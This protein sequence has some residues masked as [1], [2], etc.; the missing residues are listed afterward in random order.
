MHQLKI[1]ILLVFFAVGL[2]AAPD[3]RRT[4]LI[5]VT[6]VVLGAEV[7]YEYR[8]ANWAALH[9]PVMLGYVHGNWL[10]GIAKKIDPIF[11]G[12]SGLDDIDVA[13][14]DVMAGLGVK[15]Y[16]DGFDSS[17]SWYLRVYGAGGYL[18]WNSDGVST[19]GATARITLTG[20][21]SWVWDSGFNF[22]LG[23]GATSAWIFLG[24]DTRWLPL[25][26]LDLTFGY[27]W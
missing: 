21:Y 27:A 22:A 6:P 15:F 7:V 4:Q 13:Y 2:N 16:F 19:P 8:L 9:V 18:N 1:T 17:R 20:G 26:K 11:S 23:I 3:A 5:S 10:S 12:L 14:L 24:K 25:P